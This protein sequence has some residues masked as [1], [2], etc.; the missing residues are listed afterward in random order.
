VRQNEVD[1]FQWLIHMLTDLSFE[2][3][4]AKESGQ[5]EGKYYC[6]INVYVTGVERTPKE[7]KPLY[8]AKK[9]NSNFG[10][11]QPSFTADQLYGRH[12]N[13]SDTL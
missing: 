5:I 8:R 2:Y 13:L 6:E 4:R 11:T 1:S 9:E 7:L 12:A 10:S 3:K